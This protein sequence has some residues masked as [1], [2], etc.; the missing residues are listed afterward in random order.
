MSGLLFTF[1]LLEIILRI[2]GLI[3]ISL[4]EYHNIKSFRR[5]S[6]YTI[7]CL[8]ESMTADKWP[9]FLESLLNESQT[10]I[11]VCVLNKGVVATNT[12]AI[13]SRLEYNIDKYDPDIII[14]MMG[15]NDN[16]DSFIY[17]STRT[18][19]LKFIR[20]LKILKLL[21]LLNLHLSAKINE[22][23]NNVQLDSIVMKNNP[24][25]DPVM[26][27]QGAS[28]KISHAGN[29]GFKEYF[30]LKA[31]GQYYQDQGYYLKAESIYKQN[32]ELY[33]D[34]EPVYLDL[35]ELYLSAHKLEQVEKMCKKAISL[36]PS[37]SDSY[38]LLGRI[39]SISGDF[40]KA[41]EQYKKMFAL[42]LEVDSAYSNIGRFYSKH[43]RD[44]IA[45][46]MF[47]EALKINPVHS[48]PLS[49]LGELY[50]NRN[51]YK[52]A[53]AVL[54]K[55]LTIDPQHHDAALLLKQLHAKN[56]TQNKTGRLM[57]ESI[58]PL[59]KT[60][61]MSPDDDRSRHQMVIAKQKSIH[62]IDD[63]PGARKLFEY[64]FP[65]TVENYRT[66]RR[67]LKKHR[68]QLMCVQYPLR[69][70]A[71]LKQIFLNPDDI[72]FVDN[73]T[74]FGDAIEDEGYDEYFK[75]NFAHDFGHL[76][77]KGNW[78]FA[79]N[80]AGIIKSEIFAEK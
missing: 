5:D 36:N 74:L 46:K 16:P 53:E 33:P 20:S 73:E 52:K 60:E 4:Q 45:E 12:G 59:P 40:N 47:L 75:D 51:D 1:V 38:T 77:D 50:I 68:I 9:R 35:A 10:G 66:L 76:T 39:Y 70:I 8:G 49:E 80:I 14:V 7:L 34:Y 55:A 22:H 78:L 23:K 56:A 3:H 21:K 37:N 2:G 17:D 67:T 48:V 62:N 43:K 42:S 26:F 27:N 41:E 63:N 15:I 58:P 6:E 25:T 31:L 72:I 29:N 69:K 30:R 32:A 64:Y 28:S 11:T 61:D 54:I 79:E 44:A 13:V 71:P 19:K 57:A 18:P 24:A 65:V